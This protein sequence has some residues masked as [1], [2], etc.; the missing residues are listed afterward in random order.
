MLW[1]TF[2][3]DVDNLDRYHNPNFEAGSGITD[4]EEIQKEL[5][6]LK[7]ELKNES[8]PQAFAK[9]IEHVLKNAAIEVRPIDWFGLNIAGWIPDRAKF[10]YRVM[11]GMI[12]TWEEEMYDGTT[13][14][15]DILKLRDLH[16]DTGA[17]WSY[18]DNDHSKPYWDDILPLGINGIID[19]VKFYRDEKIKNGEYTEEMRDFYEPVIRVYEAFV[20]LLYRFADCCEKHLSDNEKM[21][22]MHKALLNI[23]KQPPKTLY[24]VMLLVY[25]YTLIQEYVTG[26]QTRTLGNI[27]TLWRP[28][29]EAALADG[30]LTRDNVKEL[31]KYFYMQYEMAG[32]PHAQPVFFA[33]TDG[34]GNDL[35]NDLSYVFLEAYEEMNIISPKLQIAVSEKTPDAYIRKCC[36]MIRAGHTSIAFANEELGRASQKFFTDDEEDMKKLSL[37]GCYNFSLKENI[38]PESVGISFV[39]GIELVLNNGIDPLSGA[40]LGIKTGEISEFDSF[41][42]FFDAYMSQTYKLV[43]DAVKIADFYDRHFLEM[44]PSP[45]LSANFEHAVRQGKDVYFNGAKYHNTVITV[46]C[47]GSATDSLYAIKKYVYDQ[48][49][50]SLEEFK[51]ILALNWKGY[52]DLQKEIAND[53]EKYGNN[54]DAVDYI[55]VD[56]MKKTADKIYSYRTWL[57]ELFAP[58][59]EGIDHGIRFGKKTGAT[60]DGRFARDQLSKNLQSVFGCDRRGVLAYIN[61]ATKIDALPYTNG[62]PIDFVLH[63][64]AVAGEE[65]LDIMVSLIR[66]TFKKGGAAIQGNV[67]NAEI[68]KDAQKHPEK[69]KGLQVRLCGWSQ[70]FNKLSRDEQDML[71]RQ[72]ETA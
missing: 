26:I 37:S 34:E 20:A 2:D 69:Y 4:P 38:Q 55:A 17:G 56:I 46:S 39:K 60:P 19:R 72:A 18:P 66:T 27:D 43:D 1:N 50:L 59:G 49:R 29:Y 32:H 70:Y 42:K 16:G 33:G 12:K 5:Y 35:V 52:E 28:Y 14:G 6:R 30:S 7:E 64:T 54:I 11:Q 41:E 48:K 31:I 65:G 23:A 63:P 62:A 58:D 3:K 13:D 44:S 68:L 25:V 36:D 8:H 10:P 45:M 24:E 61:S 21:P 67:Y 40:E 53:S 15:Y 47:I 9:M 71:I 51:N 57:G 22:I